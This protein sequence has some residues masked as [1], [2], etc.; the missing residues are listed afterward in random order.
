MK[1]RIPSGILLA[2]CLSASPLAG[3]DTPF[4]PK[5]LSS[6]T[7]GKPVCI[8]VYNRNSDQYLVHNLAQ[9]QERLSPCS[10]FKIP[11]T[12]I[13]LETDVLI[14]PGDEKKWDGTEH[15]R[16][17]LNQDH[18]LAAAIRYSVV[19]YFQEVALDIGPERMQAW[20]DDFSYGN[21]DISG[22]QDRFWLSS[23]LKI[24]A[25]EQIQFMAALN[26][27][28]LPAGSANQQT[29]KSL[30]LQ[31]Y[32]LPDG[33]NGEL[34]GKTGSC[35]SPEGDHG[36]FTGFLHRDDQE[37]VFAVNIKDVHPGGPKARAIA[38]EVLQ[39]IR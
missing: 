21:R 3:A 12:L 37:Y 25:L 18:D 30:L 22:G 11:N 16:E 24:S 23:S 15:P 28:E 9:C 13:A 39:D 2:G 6:Y 36:W 34:Y 31:D 5:P 7:G 33:F 26:Q 35:I 32:A 38:V 19:W 1:S 27:Q 17:V 8:A 20:L 4:W 10:T 14:G 29:V